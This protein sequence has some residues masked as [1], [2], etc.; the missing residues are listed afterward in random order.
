MSN[1]DA[2]RL[3]RRLSSSQL[4][5]WLY[6]RL[7]C[8]KAPYFASIHPVFDVL[9][10]GRAIAHMKKRRSVTNHIGTVHAIAMANLCEF[11]AGTV[12]EVSIPRSMRWIPRGMKI[13]YLG[14]ATTNVSATAIFPDV[15]EGQEQ[16][17]IV[18]VELTDTNGAV[19]AHADITMYVTPRPRT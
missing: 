15:V 14:K 1:F 19:A 6:S 18:A 11:A 7:V 9:E 16:D 3:W 12:T 5:R 10:P 13:D 2:L 4:G 8:F 17:A